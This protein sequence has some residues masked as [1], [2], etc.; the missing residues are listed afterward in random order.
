MRKNIAVLSRAG[1]W[2]GAEYLVKP[3]PG[4]FRSSRRLLRRLAGTLPGVLLLGLLAANGRA[5]TFTT[6]HSFT[7]VSGSGGW[8]GTNS[9][10]YFV[11]L[12]LLLSG[13]TLYGAAQAGGSSGCG[14][15]FALNT[16]GTGFTNLHN[17][18]ATSGTNGFY[19]SYGFGT[20]Q[21]G[22]IPNS[23]L[24]VLGNRLYGTAQAGGSSGWGTV[25]AVNT[26]G[27]SF[28]NLHDFTATS[29]SAGGG[30][31]TNSDGAGPFAGLLLSGNTLYGTTQC[32]GSAG[33]GTVFALNT[34]GTGFTNL[35]TFSATSGSVGGDGINSDGA[36]PIGG[37]IS[38]GN[39]LYGTASQGGT[40]GYGTVFA[41]NTDGTSFTN[42][43]SFTDG[44]DGR[45]PWDP[46][47]LSG[48]TLYGTADGA[49]NYGNGTVFAV[50]TNGTGFR[51]VHSFTGGSGGAYPKAGLLLSGNT[52][53]G[54][55]FYSGAASGNGT[56]FAVTTNGTGF[57][58]L[59][60]FAVPPNQI[61]NPAVALVLS[62]TTLFGASF[63]DGA[64]GNGTVFSLSYPAPQLT[65]MPSGT[66]VNLTWPTAVAGFSYSG[67][68]LQSTTNLGAA[69]VWTTNL[70]PPAVVNGQYAMTNAI[71]G[72]QQ[73]FRLS[74]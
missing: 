8:N 2:F 69:A 46:L 44:S 1:R 57:T 3:N 65:I 15:L 52:L 18:T 34:D 13:H 21:D 36:N 74:Q 49:G 64:Y 71:S 62:D 16:D 9:D 38:S 22:A 12:G 6:L 43:H 42:L 4:S 40:Y 48:N 67:Y 68:T 24:I 59:H 53:Y 61:G 29:G 26:D 27:T 73:F 33:W 23:G 45:Y 66:N 28:T 70:P 56:V 58:V 39:T 11:Y 14:T 30:Y 54:T 47:I 17:F 5:Q 63:A 32:G 19:A 50:N 20:N 72:S 37:L 7:A 55:T 25:F 60:A 35:H 31:G 10:G 41:L 51:T